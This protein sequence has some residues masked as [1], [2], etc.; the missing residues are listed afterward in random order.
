MGKCF[1]F[2]CVLSKTSG[3]QGENGV[4]QFFILR[5]ERVIEKGLQI[6]HARFC[7]ILKNH[8][9]IVMHLFSAVYVQKIFDFFQASVP[10]LYP[11]KTSK[12]SGFFK[13]SGGIEME[14][15]SQMG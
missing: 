14:N 10:F 1:S 3:K 4:Q 12:K 11:L 13:F 8:S 6:I 5:K 7:V 2:L 9:L 15:R